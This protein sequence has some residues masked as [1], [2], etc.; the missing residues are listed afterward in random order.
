MPRSLRS[1]GIPH[2]DVRRNRFMTTAIS[3]LSSFVVT[4][5]G[6][7]VTQWRWINQLKSKEYFT[8]RKAT[9]PFEKRNKDLTHIVDSLTKTINEKEK[10]IERKEEEINGLKF[11]IHSLNKQIDDI[12]NIENNVIHESLKDVGLL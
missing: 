9:E 8:I 11:T 12:S 2:F 5:L 4:L 3:I 10:E 7:V 1:L 6:I